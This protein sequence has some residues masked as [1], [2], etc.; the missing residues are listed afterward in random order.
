MSNRKMFA[1]DKTIFVGHKK[2]LNIEQ[3]AARL[4]DRRLSVVAEATGISYQTLLMIRD[5]HQKNP[6]LRIIQ[7]LSRYLKK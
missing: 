7:V 3:I 1:G 4:K 5:G 6:T 2:M